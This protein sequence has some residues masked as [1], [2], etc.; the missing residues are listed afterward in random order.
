V[1]YLGR[2]LADADEQD[3]A[4]AHAGQGGNQG[5]VGSPPLGVAGQQGVDFVHDYHRLGRHPL[6]QGIEVDGV[7][8]IGELQAD[9][10]KDGAAGG[11]V[12]FGDGGHPG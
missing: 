4:L 7:D 5:A 2:L 1:G 6:G 9:V 10:G 11:V 8:A 3:F 12:G